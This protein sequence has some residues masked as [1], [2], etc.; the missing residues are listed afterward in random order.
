MKMGDIAMRLNEK[1][2]QAEVKS[3][4]IRLRELRRRRWRAFVFAR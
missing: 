3:I 1:S 4:I 2:R